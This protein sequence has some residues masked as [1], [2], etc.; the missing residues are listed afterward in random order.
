M[1]TNG[2]DLRTPQRKC[3]K[4]NMRYVN[5]KHVLGEDYSSTAS[6]IISRHT[7]FK[8]MITIQ[9]MG[10]ND[11]ARRSAP[12]VTAYYK[13]MSKVACHYSGNVRLPSW[14]RIQSCLSF[15]SVGP[16]MSFSFV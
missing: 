4:E 7:V 10:F 11:T 6:L 5:T 8:D 2:I 16:R 13:S 14:N 3:V 9:S 15:C 12:A 1:S